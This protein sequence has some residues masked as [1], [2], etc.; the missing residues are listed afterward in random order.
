MAHPSGRAGDGAAQGAVL[1]ASDD[2]R[3]AR[4]AVLTWFRLRRASLGATLLVS[5][6][7]S[8]GFLVLPGADCHDHG[9]LPAFVEHDAAAHRFQAD[10]S[11]AHAH[12]LHCLVCHWAR[13]FQPTPEATFQPVA[14]AD[15]GPRLHVESFVATPAALAAQPPLRS[16]PAA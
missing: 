7:T 2:A 3:Y 13:S 1:T 5:L 9:C 6:A 15:D 8:G 4:S 14:A 10:V 12:P 16:P 11:T